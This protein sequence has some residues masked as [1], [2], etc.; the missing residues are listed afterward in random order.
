M[1]ASLYSLQ[2]NWKNMKLLLLPLIAFPAWL[3]VAKT[4]QETL[5][6]DKAVSLARSY[7]GQSNAFGTDLLKHYLDTKPGEN[8]FFSPFSILSAVS[9]AGEGA[10]G[11]TQTEIRKTF[12]LP[13]TD[14]LRLYGFMALNQLLNNPRAQFKLNTSNALWIHQGASKL[15]LNPSFQDAA[16]RY[17]GASAQYTDFLDAEKSSRLISD[18]VAKKTEQRIKDLV[19]SSDITPLTRLI[20]TNTIYFKADWAAMFTKEN[21][22]D[23][24]FTMRDG[25]TIQARMMSQEGHFRYFENGDAEMLEMPYQNNELSMVVILP[26]GSNMLEN[27][28]VN[29]MLASNLQP[30]KLFVKLPKFTYESGY[31]LKPDLITLGMNISFTNAADFSGV[32]SAMPLKISEVIHKAFVEVTEGGTEAAAAT[33]VIMAEI[34]SVPVYREPKIFNANHPFLFLI[35]HNASGAILFTGAMNKPEFKEKEQKSQ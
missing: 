7:S 29:K 34:T 28:D 20:L 17:Y 31:H 11:N 14:S 3:M 32:S 12:H 16:T 4:P 13:A 21:T 22:R 10:R 33:A 5:P 23:L 1:Q 2:I 24:P 27:I 19:K 25:K 30:M 26:K 35:R 6:T 8:I 9:M 15:E 18:F